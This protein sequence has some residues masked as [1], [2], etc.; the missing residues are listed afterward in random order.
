MTIP[1]LK[2]LLSATGILLHKLIWIESNP[3][4]STSHHLC[5]H[6]CLKKK[7]RTF[8]KNSWCQAHG[9]F[10][11]KS[12]LDEMPIHTGGW[13]ATPGVRNSSSSLTKPTSDPPRMATRRIPAQGGVVN[14]PAGL[15]LTSFLE[16]SL[17]TLPSSPWPPGLLPSS[18]W[19]RRGFFP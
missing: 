5:S 9:G 10:P 3:V 8:C 11:D 7:W 2:R 1:T 12:S 19:P 6:R 15:R 13:T 18:P 4:C 17:V 16:T 14:S